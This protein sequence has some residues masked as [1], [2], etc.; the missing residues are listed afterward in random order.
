VADLSPD[1]A[2]VG[3]CGK[4]GCFG[5]RSPTEHRILR[6][7]RCAQGVR[8]LRGETGSSVVDCSSGPPVQLKYPG[9]LCK[10]GGRTIPI[11]ARMGL[12]FPEMSKRSPYRAR[13]G[14]GVDRENGGFGEGVP[15][16]VLRRERGFGFAGNF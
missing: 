8:V 4:K 6:R 1:Q 15:G 12:R 10:T 13:I 14:G 9:L 11:R 16:G 3:S 5:D 2:P 7:E